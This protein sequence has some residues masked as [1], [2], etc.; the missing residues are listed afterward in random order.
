[1]L[2][3]ERISQ[4]SALPQPEDGGIRLATLIV[5]RLT[6]HMDLSRYRDEYR[7]RLEELIRAKQRGL[8]IVIPEK[9][10]ELPARR[11]MDTLRKTAESLR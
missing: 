10:K 2:D 5:E 3:P 6:A 8:T 9:A 1:M 11:L 4:V 7:E